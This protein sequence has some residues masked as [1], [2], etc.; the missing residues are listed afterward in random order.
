MEAI[1]VVL[2]LA[3]II[4]LVAL[5]AATRRP[6]SSPSFEAGRIVEQLQSL[7]AQLAPLPGIRSHLDVDGRLW[8]EMSR[9]IEETQRA[10]DALRLQAEE[11]RRRDEDLV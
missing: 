10:I 11:R 7:Q 2:A 9:R 8:E 3:L 4:T 6:A 5:L 1:A